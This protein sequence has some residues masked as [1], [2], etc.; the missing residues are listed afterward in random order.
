MGA[1]HLPHCVKPQKDLLGPGEGGGVDIGGYSGPGQHGGLG[2]KPEKAC[3]LV[4]QQAAS[5]GVLGLW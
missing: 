5:Q 2:E 1:Q 4:T 3:R